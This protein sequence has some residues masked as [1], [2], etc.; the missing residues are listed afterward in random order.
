MV[1]FLHH[2]VFLQLSKLFGKAPSKCKNEVYSTLIRNFPFF[3]IYNYKESQLGTVTK[4]VLSD[5]SYNCFYDVSFLLI[6]ENV[7]L[8]TYCLVDCLLPFFFICL[9]I[10]NSI[11]KEMLLIVDRKFLQQKSLILSSGYFLLWPSLKSD[12]EGW[13][14]NHFFWQ[15]QTLN[16]RFHNVLFI[17]HTQINIKCKKL[18]QQ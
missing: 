6:R 15:V 12:R 8:L 18:S 14:L 9:L 17:P 16:F 5:S 3:I 4:F 1:W 2:Q 7:L 10:I 11:Y 13:E